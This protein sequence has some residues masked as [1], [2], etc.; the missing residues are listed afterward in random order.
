M[1]EPA[2]ERATLTLVMLVAATVFGLGM[3]WGLPTRAVDPYL[4][5]DRPVWSGR[6]IIGLAPADTGEHGA[7]VDANPIL[8][9]GTTVIV[10]ETDRQ[11]A[12]IVRRYRLFSHQ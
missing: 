10:N 6:E 5:G 1:V 12:E 2:Q 4:F 7:D 9:R 8:N 3:S 11:R